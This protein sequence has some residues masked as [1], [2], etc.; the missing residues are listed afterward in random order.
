MRIQELFSKD[1]TRRINPAVVVSEMDDYSVNQ[2]IE[3]YVFTPTIT[4][5]IYKFLNAI[6]NNKDGK[7]GV[8]ISG[9]YGSGKSH[10]IK[11]LYYCLREQ[12]KDKAFELFKDSLALID[13]LDEPNLGLLASLQ[14]RLAKLKVEEIIF[15]I[16]AVSENN[17]SKERITRVLLNQLNQFR[18]YNNTNIALALY[19]EK[20]LDKAGVFSQFKDLIKSTFNEQWEGNQIRFSRRYL[21][22]IIE[23]AAQFDTKIDRQALKDTILNK[24]QDYTIEFLIEELKDYLQ[25]KSDDHRLVFMM[26]EV[27]QYIG[28][29][30]SLLLNLQT[31]VEEIGSKIGQRVWVVCTAQQELSN[32]INNTDD[33]TEDFGKIFARFETMISLESQDAAFITKKRVLDK[34]SEGVGALNEFYKLNKGAIENQFVMNHD[35]YQ[36]YNNREDFTLTYPF[37]PYQFRLISDVF[38]S[39]SNVGYVGEG[40]KNTE[41]A[42][43]GITHYTAKLCKENEIGYFVPFDL[44]FNEQL[45]KNLTHLARNILDRAYKIKEVQNEKFARRVVNSLFMVSNLGDSKSVNFPANV[46]NISL[47]MM[48]AVDTSKMEIQ[49]KVQEV[50]DVLVHK[51]ILQVAEGKFRFLKEDEIEV[52]QMI[53]N[54]PLPG[55]F[56]LEY[57]YE[58]VISKVLKPDQVVAF[59]NR[60][61]RI[62]IQI[63]DKQINQK[64]DFNLKFSVY[65]T[66]DLLQIAHNTPTNDMVVGINE[67]FKED[68][69]FKTKVL[70]YCRTKRYIG[71]S[72]TTA[73]GSRVETLKGFKENNDLL[74]GEILKKFAR[75]FMETNMISKNQIIRAEELNTNNAAS[76]F[77]QM[78]KRHMEETYNK[79]HLAANYANSNNAL[80][81]HARSK[82]KE[83]HATLTPAEEEMNTKL[84]FEGESAVAGDMV[85]MFEKAPYG[86]KDISSLDVILRLAQKGVRRFEWKGEEVDLIVYAEK[87]LNSKERDGITIH[88]E[89]THSAEEV[90]AFIHAVNNEIFA[91]TLIP[92]DIRD[93]KTAVEALKSKLKPIITRLNE[94]KDTYESK[95][96]GIHLKNYY[97]DLSEIYQSRNNEEVLRQVIDQKSKISSHRDNYKMLEEFLENNL[98]AYDEIENFIRENKSNCESLDDMMQV[99]AAELAD[100]FKNDN[101]PWD[102]FPQIKKAYKE[103]HKALAAF[104]EKLRSQVLQTYELIF[105]EID[106][107]RKS[108]HIDEPYHATD[109]S[110]FLAKIRNEK[111]VAQ[112]EISLLKADEFRANGFKV[113]DDYIAR[114]KA[115]VSGKEYQVSTHIALAKEM[116]PTTIETPE[117]LDDYLHQL[118]AK[119][120]VK[121]AKDKKLFIN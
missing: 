113:L 102:K 66:S 31:I 62:S 98:S 58:D 35:L 6:A 3:E 67:W 11:F 92:S 77:Q 52:A 90:A 120:M 110:T 111:K 75:K 28:T 23:I 22:K 63:D 15:N 19:L 87:A 37:I 18:G 30:T 60:N 47:L 85:R 115:K 39:F 20:P 88:R 101:D 49:Q 10:F 48:D 103:L 51:N 106:E 27:S 116:P 59:G 74:L 16:D 82:Q 34:K 105:N 117:Q 97:R 32:L 70:N 73:T 53:V 9:Y 12:T 36:N 38:D 55:E 14:H 86:W 56:R 112:L 99:K 41:R 94:E 114:Q 7:T 100:Y 42:I 72:A 104:V 46:E 2:E 29:N 95:A 89:K 17:D 44:F 81:E 65:E 91:E 108:L 25:E 26:D 107:H 64:G 5:N 4:R 84:S 1:I 121:L 69:D 8:W 33:Q 93:L 76:R 83:L 79:H 13:P 61:F 50:L 71:L 119:L 78:V 109:P 68:N 45:E 96:F 54:T 43:L 57:F 21:D 80:L 24:S 118:R 40:V